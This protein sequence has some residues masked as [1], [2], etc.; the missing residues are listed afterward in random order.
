MPLDRAGA[1][2][3]LGATA[4][5]VFLRWRSHFHVFGPIGGGRGREMLSLVEVLGSN[6]VRSLNLT[7][8]HLFQR[9]AISNEHMN[10]TTF[11][12]NNQFCYKRFTLQREPK[13]GNCTKVHLTRKIDMVEHYIINGWVKN[14]TSIPS[15][16]SLQHFNS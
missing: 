7:S 8:W 2:T 16:P 5:S 15:L 13:L 12:S 6:N 10:H 11:V 1:K 9:V 14:I 4:R 3:K